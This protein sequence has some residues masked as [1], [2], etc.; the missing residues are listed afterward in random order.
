MELQS[1]PL[2]QLDQY[3]QHVVLSRSLTGVLSH[4]FDLLLDFPPLLLLALS[5]QMVTK[6][7]PEG[8][9]SQRHFL[10]SWAEYLAHLC[11]PAL[12]ASLVFEEWTSCDK[13]IF[14]VFSLL[15]HRELANNAKKS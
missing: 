11:S 8:Q 15:C 13:N 3:Y 14:P 6:A 7:P 12:S 4:S 10:F 5:C 9:H 1:N 2:G